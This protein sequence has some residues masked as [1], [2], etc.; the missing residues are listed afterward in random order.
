VKETEAD[1]AILM[2]D[3]STVLEPVGTGYKHHQVNHREE[4]YVR[5]EDGLCI[6]TN[7]VGRRLLCPLKRSNYGRLPPLGARTI[8]ISTCAN[9]TSGTTRAKGQRR[10]A[11]G[12]SA[13]DRAWQAANAEAAKDW[14]PA[15]SWRITIIE[16]Y[17]HVDTIFKG[18]RMG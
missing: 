17:G 7:T 13:D 11:D 8:R 6:A 3:S 1:D 2:M 12:V 16:A 15:G 4:E 18:S 9:S 5:H 14:N 10:S